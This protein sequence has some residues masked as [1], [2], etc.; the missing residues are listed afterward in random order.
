MAFDTADMIK[1]SLSGS[2]L[3]FR[4]YNAVSLWVKPTEDVG[5]DQFLLTEDHTYRNWGLWLD[6]D[7]K[8]N[9]KVSSHIVKADITVPLNEWTHISAVHQPAESSILLYINGS[10]AASKSHERLERTVFAGDVISIGGTSIGVVEGWKE[11]KFVGVLDEISIFK[12]RSPSEDILPSQSEIRQIFNYQGAWYDAYSE[13]KVIIDA[14]DPTIEL[15]LAETHL[16]KRDVVLPIVAQ[17]DTSG[18]IGV[19]YQINDGEWQTPT[20]DEGVWTFTYSPSEVG[21]QTITVFTMDRVGNSAL[22]IKTIIIEDTPPVVTLNGAGER[23]PQP[24]TPEEDT[25][26]WSATL[27]GKA[28]ESGE[29]D[30]GVDHLTVSV[31]DK[32]GGYIGK[33][34]TVTSFGDDGEWSVDYSLGLKP[35]G[36]YPVQIEAVDKVGNRSTTDFTIALESSP[37]TADLLNT[38]PFVDEDGTEQP[39]VMAGTGDKRPTIVGTI[40]DVPSP[41]NSVLTMHFEEPAGTT[42]FADSSDSRLTATCSGDACPQAASE[43]LYGY[44][45]AFDGNDALTLTEGPTY[46]RTDT[47]RESDPDAYAAAAPLPIEEMSVVARVYVDEQNNMDGFVSAMQ[48]VNGAEGGWMLGSRNGRFVFGLATDDA[49]DGDGFITYL[50]ARETYTTG[51]WY[52]VI[53]TYDGSRMKIYVDGEFQATTDVQSGPILYPDSAWYGIG[54]YRDGDETYPFTGRLDEIAVY[55]Y[56]LS[57]DDVTTMFAPAS[58]VGTLE[59]ALQHKRDEIAGKPL[60]WQNVP[61]TS[62]QV[63]QSYTRWS[64]QLPEGF[65]GVYTISLRATDA[66]GNTTIIPDVWE[67]MIDTHAPRINL[68]AK[69]VNKGV[70]YTTTFEDFNFQQEG[71]ASPCGIEIITQQDNYTEMWYGE[72][73]KSVDADGNIVPAPDRPYRLTAQCVLPGKIGYEEQSTLDGHSL[74]LSGDVA[75]LF[76]GKTMKSFDMSDLSSPKKMHTRKHKLYGVAHSLRVD[77]ATGRALLFFGDKVLARHVV[78]KPEKMRFTGYTKAREFKDLAIQGDYGYVTY[79]RFTHSLDIY[80]I[81]RNEPKYV[82]YYYDTYYKPHMEKTDVTF[83]TIEAITEKYLFLNQGDRML[84]VDITSSPDLKKVADVNKP[85]DTYVV[86]GDYLYAVSRSGFSIYDISNIEDIPIPP[87]PNCRK[88]YSGGRWC[89]RV[90][91]ESLSPVGEYYNNQVKPFDIAVQGNTAYLV[92]KDGSSWSTKY[93][94]YVFD[95]TDKSKPVLFSTYKSPSTITDIEVS[96]NALYVETKDWRDK[97]EQR[98]L[99]LKGD[100]LLKADACDIYGN[101]TD[102]SRDTQTYAAQGVNFNTTADLPQASSSPPSVAPVDVSV[103]PL[104]SVLSEPEPIT[105]SLSLV[106]EAGMKDLTVTMEGQ[107]LTTQSWSQA[108]AV[109]RTFVSVPWTPPAEGSYSLVVEA[110]DHAGNTDRDDEMTI[111]LD[112]QPP[113]VGVHQSA[114]GLHQYDTAQDE[115]VLSGEVIDDASLAYLDVVLTMGDTDGTVET[116]PVA[117]RDPGGDPL[118]LPATFPSGSAVYATMQWEARWAL[119]NAIPSGLDAT[120][121]VT[122]TDLAGRESVVEQPLVIDGVAPSNVDM[123]LSYNADGNTTTIITPGMTLSEVRDP[124]MVISWEPA[125]D[126]NGIK[127][128]LVGWTTSPEVN[129]SELASY[130][131]GSASHTQQ[132]GDAQRWYAHVVAE[133]QAGNRTTTTRGPIYVDY[134][135]TPTYISMEENGT[136]PYRSW[137]EASCSMVGMDNR[138][139]A[140]KN[141]L[142]S[143]DDGQRFYATWN[144]D[145]L[146]MM[147]TGAQWETDGD[148]FIYLDTKEGGSSQLYD[149][150]PATI[151]NTVILLPPRNDMASLAAI[152]S[153]EAASTQATSPR[154]IVRPRLSATSGPMAADTLIWVQS[155]D[156]AT[157]MQWDGEAWQTVADGLSYHFDQNLPTP[158]TDLYVPFSTLGISEPAST[159]LSLL[160]VASEEDALRLWATMPPRNNLNSERIVDS[161]GA[162]E[163]QQFALTKS[164]SWQL[165]DGMCPGVVSDTPG[166]AQGAVVQQ[167]ATEG[168][169]TGADMS[170]SISSYPSGV[171]Y[172]LL[173]DNLFFAMKDLPQFAGVDWGGVGNAKATF[174]ANNPDDPSCERDTAKPTVQGGDTSGV[175]LESLTPIGGGVDFNVQEELNATMSVDT[176]PLGNGNPVVYTIE[177]QNTGTVASRDV[178][179]D[180][181]TWGP[182]RLPG[183]EYRTDAAGEYDYQ[184]LQVGDIAAGERRAIS[185]PA[186]VDTSFDT[187]NQHGKATIDVTVYDS[188]GSHQHLD[189]GSDIYTNE[190]EWLYVD[191]EVDTSP[192]DYIEI[193]SPRGIL[194]RGKN[195]VSGFVYDRSLVPQV[196]VEVLLP[197]GSSRMLTCEDDTP[198]DGQWECIFDAGSISDG[199]EVQMRARATD[200]YGAT[201]AWSGWV[202]FIVDTIAPTVLLDAT[203]KAILSDGYIGEREA[204]LSGTLWDNVQPSGIEVCRTVDNVNN[205]DDTDDTAEVCEQLPIVLSAEDERKDTYIYEDVPLNPAEVG[206]NTPCDNPLTRGFDVPEEDNFVLSKVSMGLNISHT[207]RSDLNV[208]LQSPKGTKVTMLYDGTNAQNYNVLIDDAS[209]MLD[210]DDKNDHSTNSPFYQNQRGGYGLLSAFKGENAAGRWTLSICDAYPAEDDGFYNRSQLFLSKHTTPVSTTAMWEYEVP[211]DEPLAVVGETMEDEA[212]DE[213]AL[214]PTPADPTTPADPPTDGADPNAG[215]YTLFMP[216]ISNGDTSQVGDADGSTGDIAPTPPQPTDDSAS[217]QTVA[218]Y[219][220]DS[221]GNRSVEPLRFTYVVDNEPPVIQPS[222]TTTITLKVDDIYTDSTRLQVSGTVNDQ[223]SGV[224]EMWFTVMRPESVML[225]D[226]LTVTNGT[227]TYSSTRLLGGAGT[228]QWWAE[229]Y[230]YAGNLQQVGPYTI[231]VEDDVEDDVDAAVSDMP[232]SSKDEWSAQ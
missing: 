186:I 143:L 157:L 213:A 91:R 179:V 224:R 200:T 171:A 5:H 136:T 142:A 4:S 202:P 87:T 76:D 79:S 114:L 226:P 125:N 199:A 221:M 215:G 152:Q 216:L 37:P 30:S 203:S 197:D 72:T 151:T 126:A 119:T 20:F 29:H 97:K 23:T 24:L 39:D 22:S 181:Y 218:I 104:P 14:D 117:V 137:A 161:A 7:F 123:T 210:R 88:D 85:A 166:T 184:S 176:P 18:V 231:V 106:A 46:R 92:V 89:D 232:A 148:L 191:H 158:T 227:W 208:M 204:L 100:D 174:C 150:Y 36:F 127:Q 86:E 168:S 54:S 146:R 182:I 48:S 111:L 6:E 75:F 139:Y 51:Q 188:T 101:C 84:V 172:S 230:D 34:K 15:D 12:G 194:T 43:G 99:T 63:G 95:I 196:E 183:G 61:L 8:P 121:V 164:Y 17:D 124:E 96:S 212:G 11:R 102:F 170:V 193:Q 169:P 156:T 26:S 78:S 57:S 112:T 192:P 1:I 140:R 59:V 206:A 209:T 67:G 81:S 159:T 21:E 229:A 10:L 69:N 98:V 135:T 38:T 16:A 201:G 71:F 141:N 93:F 42:T 82:G 177:L 105:I 83:M 60:T 45:V 52:T 25:M 115:F 219:G 205:T 77:D 32:Y 154:P 222:N 13:H 40:N 163:F 27:S 129:L 41:P 56:A 149:P 47:L 2:D 49:D 53:G 108:D 167:D 225:T 9:F 80:S 62:G 214:E 198:D 160:A 217:T 120:V 145:G 64:Y 144:H 122:A 73:Y 220:L 68:M 134:A 195:V 107:T 155:D 28:T 50:E 58:G 118:Y 207:L 31:F 132:V 165:A 33:P 44:G 175:R 90:T 173:N 223:P 189:D 130:D 211:L 153:A 110:T 228:Y 180:I 66:S 3:N 133:D 74:E 116:L 138:I 178:V 55:D 109:T 35:D 187:Q 65:E 162:S 131:P 94:V 185:F 19:I 128:Y 103:G 70:E 113:Q 190:L 147:W